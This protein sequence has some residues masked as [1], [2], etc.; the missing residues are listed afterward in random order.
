MELAGLSVGYRSRG[1][2]A[3]AVDGLDLTIAPG[4]TVAIVGESGSGKTTT[5]NAILGLLP[6]NGQVVAGSIRVAGTD[7]TTARERTLRAVRGSVV[8]LVPQ[9]PMVGLNPTMRVGGQVAEAV[10]RRG[11]DRRLVPAE[12]VEALERAGLDEPV[13]R[14]RQYPHE[15]SGG[16]RQ[17]V[18]IA[19]ALAG[20]P[21]LI[22][23]DEPTS[24]LDVTVQR[25]ILDHLGRLVAETGTSLLIITHDLGVAADR[26]DRVVVMQHGRVV[27]RGDPESIML[28]PRDPY[29]RHLIEAAPALSH[30]GQVVPRFTEVAPA[31]EILRLEAVTKDFR[32]PRTSGGDRV[33]RALEDV[34]L[35]VRAGQTLGLVGESGSGKT[36]ALRIAMALDKPTSGRV[37]LDG[38]DI[39]A[40]GWSQLRP[41]RRR[42][43]LVHQ[44]PYSSLDPRFSVEESIAEPLVSFR[45]GNRASRAVRVRELLDQVALPADFR[46]RRPRELSG[47]QRQRVAIARALALGPELVFLDEP[48]SALDVSVQDQILGLL[49]GLQRELGVSYFFISHDLAV[50]AQLSHEVAVLRRGRI[51][52][53]GPAAAV[54]AAPEQEH[55]RE[56]LGAI[57]GQRF[58]AA[59]AA[60]ARPEGAPARIP[61]PGTD[62]IP[63]GP[64]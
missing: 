27:E 16:M 35:S 20:H 8:G 19:I 7:I 15:L 38:K 13:L 63:V 12:V 49:T 30:S 4:E 26:A 61:P 56:L 25:T 55:T 60:A 1:R 48:V 47:G 50:V 64:E 42:F 21:R 2:T 58:A 44:N 40:A 31:P 33:F 28:A 54:F 41:L 53:S 17:R 6:A 37:F 29:T 36:T 5:A 24:A 51:V 57:P 46:D 34:T 45:V 18:L 62:G 9:D 32:L 10:R 11:V 59:L 43:Q 14:A 22:V 52:E 3:L 23:A 39:T